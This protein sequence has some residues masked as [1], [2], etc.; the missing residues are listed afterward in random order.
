MPSPR[1]KH[2][3]LQPRCPVVAAHH[4]LTAS[5]F[6]SAIVFGLA[7]LLAACASPGEPQPPRPVI[8]AAVSD[9]A[10]RQ[11]GD[12][13]VLTFTPPTK[14]VEGERL[15]GLPTI[16]ILRGFAP[17]GEKAPP[18]GSLRIVY[19]V[20]PQV[21][22]SYLVQDRVEFTDP[23]KP[24][25]TTKHGGERLFY[26][27][28]ARVSKR[29][30]STDSNAASFVF[31]PAPAPI[32]TVHTAVIEAGVQLSWEAPAT[33]SGGAALTSLAG[34]RIYRAEAEPGAAPPGGAA[35][36]TRKTPPILAGISPSTSYL[37]A[38]IVWGKTYLYTVRSVAQY[39][40]E[41]VESADSRAALVT[42][43]DIF[44]PAAPRDLVAVYVAPA[45]AAPPGGVVELSWAISPEPDVAGYHVYRAGEG[46]EKPQ[47]VNHNLLPTP[48]FRDT[49]LIPGAHYT[50]T[51][52]AVDRSGNE[53]QPSVRVSM[54]IP[55][56]GG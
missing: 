56:A 5:H 4:F 10:A 27:V 34:Y 6:P 31:H 16:E 44:P 3:N 32:A 1:E 7:L 18:S 25:D 20:P 2:R 36:A 53:S 41:A 9:L 51:V 35:E 55:K 17:P 37:D 46:E 22:D 11:L 26:A 21:L 28:R 19:T 13:A 38:Q 23:L 39:G 29:A 14:S 50:Y 8:P 40:A 49:P 52:T 47:R 30:A 48:A 12:A 15:N 24:E 45:G 33:A 43:K 54:E 42:P